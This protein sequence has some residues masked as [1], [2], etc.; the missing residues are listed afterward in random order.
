MRWALL[1]L[2]TAL[3]FAQGTK[4]KPAATEYDVHGQAGSLD[5]GAE[6][7]VHSFS[8]GEQM[9]IAED[10]LVVEV[11]L[12][13]LMKDDPITVDLKDFKLRLNHKTVLP[14]DQPAQA[15]ASLTRSP[16]SA[17]PQR[18][19]SEG[20]GAGPLGIPIG[21]QP[22]GPP[23]Q[24]PAPPRAP[25]ADP[26]SDVPREIVRPDEVLMNTALPQG[27]QKGRIAGFIYF[28][29]RGKTSSIKA[30]DLEFRGATLK[31]K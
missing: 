14:A 19:M 5:I 1:V 7:M 24:R 13:P 4:P 31:L 23:V 25:Q 20:I 8:A 3:A 17:R 26:G 22:G 27:A 21:Q 15:A 10:Y 28:P 29:Y 12:Y 2:S 30:L 11:A 18:G 6:Y 16:W 9:F